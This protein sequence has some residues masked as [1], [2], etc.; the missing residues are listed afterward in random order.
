MQLQFH[1][2]CGDEYAVPF[3]EGDDDAVAVQDAAAVHT[4]KRMEGVAAGLEGG[5]FSA[6][7]VK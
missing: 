2:V 6:F 3:E 7:R 4:Q 5:E 1:A